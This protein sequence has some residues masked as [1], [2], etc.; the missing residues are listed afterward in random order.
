M[1]YTQTTVATGSSSLGEIGAFP[2]DES[3]RVVNQTS[4][5][6]GETYYLTSSEDLVKLQ[7]LV[8]SGVDTTNVTFEL[9]NDIDME[10]VS[11]RGIGKD[12]TNAFKG[13]FNGNDNVISNLTINTTESYVGLFGYVKGAT[14]DSIGLEN[15]DITGD[16]YVGGLV[17]I[18]RDSSSI[19]N[20]YATGSV[21]AT[22]SNAYVG[23][24]V[25]I[26][27]D[28]SSITNSYATGSVT[29][30]GNYANVGGLVGCASSSNITNSY[31][32]GSVTATVSNVYVGGLVGCASSSNIT[33]SYATGSVTGTGNYAFVGGL[34]G[35]AS[36]SSITNSYA[37][38]S[39][40]ATGSNAS[41][42]G[43]VGGVYG[44][45]PTIDGY[46]DTQTTG[47][48]V[49]VGSGT[50][51]G[52]VTGVTTSQLNN[53]IS[54]GTLPDFSDGFDWVNEAMRVV[55][56]TS[57]TAG[58]TYYLTT[59][60]DLVKLQDL[61]N[62]GVDTTNVTFELMSDIDMSGVSFRGIGN[63]TYAFKGT[64]NGNDH[65]ISNLTINTTEDYVGLF[66]SVTGATI[67]SI[68]LENAN[69][70]GNNYVGGLV[71]RA[72]SGSITNSYATGSVTGNDYV[73]GL[74]G[75]ARDSSSITNSYATGSVTG[76]GNSAYVGGLVGYAAY[77]SITNSYAT[78]SVTATGS[79]AAVG[80]LVGRAS[81]G[82]ITNSYATGSVTG[83]NYVG[84]LGGNVYAGS[85]TN[86]YATGSVTGGS[87]ARVGGL[88]GY[89][90]GSNSTINGYFDQNTTGQTVGIGSINSSS[91]VS[92]TVTGVTTE[93][94]NSLIADGTLADYT[95]SDAI[96]VKNGNNTLGYIRVD[97]DTTLGEIITELEKYGISGSINNGVISLSSSN[98]YTVSGDIVDELGLKVNGASNTLTLGETEGTLSTS[99]TLDNL[100]LTSATV[101]V[102][103][104]GTQHT[105]T[106]NSSSTMQDLI[107][108]L[109]NYGI[110]ASISSDGK[111]TIQGND[112]NY[113]LGMDSNLQSKLN[114]TAPFNTTQVV[115]SY[116]NTNSDRLVN[117]DVSTLNNSSTLS[118]LGLSSDSYI[119]VV[120]NGT[121]SVITLSNSKTVGDLITELSNKG[122]TASVEDGKLTKVLQ[123]V[124]KME[125]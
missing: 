38:G 94:L 49:G 54:A 35:F 8:N 76:T 82:S 66:G 64:F 10:G 123:L 15:A 78:G 102:M 43:L 86:S 30:T 81:S 5:V 27:R 124:L 14:I 46:F 75:G 19:T 6:S 69:I 87:N 121:E 73:G 45:S 88:V 29:G 119:T 77:S 114:L 22:G 111:I 60:E 83:N 11:F 68:G 62:S 41:V 96:V 95:P 91:T 39:V 25:G 53:L 61:V 122:I 18:A 44:S 12:D 21:T 56:Q 37:T 115:N 85:I 50:Y 58:Q 84:G 65:V 63:S 34:V 51:T 125:N 98:G 26:A 48:T 89:V 113:I 32:T 116:T 99:T 20:S 4:F 79:N 92:G 101:T 108:E 71:G 28:S 70:T 31:A 97:N 36:S 47:Q 33:N 57:F 52:T 90:F 7:D 16:N 93:G 67:D 59:Y 104:N 117:E 9:M 13:T 112:N 2:V 3:K 120:Q 100:G 17:G 107:D 110:S 1:T 72:S 24:L 105:I 40:T 80:G 118:E 55:N 74:V 42:G 23:G 103:S 106:L 109:D